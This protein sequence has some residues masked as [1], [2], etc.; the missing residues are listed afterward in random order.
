[1]LDSC[2]SF[3]KDDR[4]W[5]G[6]SVTCS[7]GSPQARGGRYECSSIPVFAWTLTSHHGRTDPDSC[8]P[9]SDRFAAFVF[10]NASSKRRSLESPR[11]AVLRAPKPRSPQR[12]A[13]R[14]APNGDDLVGAFPWDEAGAGA[15][16]RNA[17]LPGCERDADKGA[18]LIKMRG[19]AA[20]SGALL[21]EP[22][23]L[24]SRV[25]TVAA[26]A[27]AAACVSPAQAP[28]LS[29]PL[30]S[31]PTCTLRRVT[32]PQTPWKGLRDPRNPHRHEA[33]ARKCPELGSEMDAQGRSFWHCRK[34]WEM[35]TL[36]LE[37]V[38]WIWVG[39]LIPWN[40]VGCKNMQVFWTIREKLWNN[41]TQSGPNYP[42]TLML[43]FFYSYWFKSSCFDLEG[44]WR[45]LADYYP[46]FR[47]GQNFSK[48]FY[49]I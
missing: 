20:P 1:M 7:L 22:G 31:H 34:Q 26:G 6:S 4:R 36:V 9:W 43:Y 24:K 23:F 46:T 14:A 2:G 29:P 25:P 8:F 39:I 40:Q 44:H 32:A 17:C 27:D 45:D 13:A 47:K 48:S 42:F 21:S 38:F 19:F 37:R 3:R 5:A 15:G 33:A 11:V 12:A 10:G 30:P 49:L 35:W 16:D 41:Y 28:A 18:D